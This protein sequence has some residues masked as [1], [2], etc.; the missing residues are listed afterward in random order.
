MFIDFLKCEIF[1]LYFELFGVC[2]LLEF[3]SQELCVNCI[4]FLEGCSWSS[5][6]KA[7]SGCEVVCWLHILLVVI[8]FIMCFIICW[9]MLY[10][11]VINV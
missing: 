8:H 10:L 9:P 2:I 5:V 3:V 7:R 11:F 1:E 4:R 6:T